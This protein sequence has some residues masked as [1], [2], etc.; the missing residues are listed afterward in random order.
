MRK[1]G[2]E[3]WTLIGI[4]AIA[5][6]V[7]ATWYFGR[8]FQ[9]GVS[10]LLGVAV[11]GTTLGFFTAFRSETIRWQDNHMRRIDRTASGLD[12]YNEK[13]RHLVIEFIR[14]YDRAIDPVMA[15]L[16]KDGADPIQ[17]DRVRYEVARDL[18][19]STILHHIDKLAWLMEQN[20]Y[21]DES[22]LLSAVA[23][24]TA[25]LFL[26]PKYDEVVQGMLE[27]SSLQHV[28]AFILR[29]KG[30]I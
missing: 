10:R 19:L 25:R 29:L 26:N 23:S 24:E 16:V 21:L 9:D 27:T 20:G 3:T 18:G 7:F 11:S 6:G 15:T 13:V 14:E 22:E 17:W 4:L 28:Q 1:W 8:T 2:I 30:G 12:Y 5:T